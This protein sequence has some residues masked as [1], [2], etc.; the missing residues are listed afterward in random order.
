MISDGVP[1]GID[2]V[3]RGTTAIIFLA[4]RDH[5]V[6]YDGSNRLLVNSNNVAYQ[7][8][9]AEKHSRGK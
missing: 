1:R 3:V 7:L 6:N 8:G 2:G 4:T 9:S 5:A